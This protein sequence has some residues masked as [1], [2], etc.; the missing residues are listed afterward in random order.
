MN[1]VWLVNRGDQLPQPFRLIELHEPRAS[2]IH[3][4]FG[5]SA[6]RR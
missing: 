4:L 6:A 5:N 2:S 3:W 1:R